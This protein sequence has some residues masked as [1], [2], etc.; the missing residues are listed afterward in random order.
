ME[1]W[2]SLGGG[3]FS[4]VTFCVV[5]SNHGPGLLRGEAC[6]LMVTP[7]QASLSGFLD[8]RRGH[9]WACFL[10]RS[11]SK[12]SLCCDLKWLGAHLCIQDSTRYSI[13]MAAGWA[14]WSSCSAEPSKV[15][16][17]KFSHR[18]LETRNRTEGRQVALQRKGLFLGTETAKENTV[19]WNLKLLYF[20][21]YVDVCIAAPPTER[22]SG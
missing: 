1:D 3:H 10:V 8:W 14:W 5:D 6:Q 17:V 21:F 19:I 18:K 20:L 9:A 13:F 4:Q 2:I 15:Q 22:N 16:P 7:V 12:H 11:C